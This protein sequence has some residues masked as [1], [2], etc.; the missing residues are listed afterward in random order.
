MLCM[1]RDSV[2]HLAVDC[3]EAGRS[4][5]TD[6]SVP[7]E[8]QMGHLGCYSCCRVLCSSICWYGYRADYDPS[9][10]ATLNLGFALEV[11]KSFK[12]S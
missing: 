12:A 7:H 1:L 5:A 10:R 8:S 11:N 3:N 6:R 4:R 9:V 2:G